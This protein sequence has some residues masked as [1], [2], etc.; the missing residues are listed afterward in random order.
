MHKQ[1]HHD[2]V[3]SN[4][5]QYQVVPLLDFGPILAENWVGPSNAKTVNW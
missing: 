5:K 1:R 4:D 2:M 3:V